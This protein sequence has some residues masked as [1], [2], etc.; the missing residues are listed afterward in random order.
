M[1]GSPNVNPAI[2]DWA[3]RQVGMAHGWK[4]LT[5][6]SLWDDMTIQAAVI[7]EQYVGT[8]INMHIAAIGRRW[9]TRQFLHAAFDYPFN[10]L[11]VVRVTGLVPDSNEASKRFCEHLGFVHEGRVR[12]A[13]TDG[14]DLIVFGMLREECR[15]LEI[16]NGKA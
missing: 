6:L 15:H 4:D 12:K 16:L 9:L 7:Y 2:G 8:S 11:R 3:R 1:A 10:Q 14:S 13:A 5:T